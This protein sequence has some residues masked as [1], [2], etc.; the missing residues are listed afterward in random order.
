MLPGYSEVLKAVLLGPAAAWE[1][2][3][4][5]VNSQLP[6]AAPWQAPAVAS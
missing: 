2:R 6:M 4:P 1:S 5:E 3:L